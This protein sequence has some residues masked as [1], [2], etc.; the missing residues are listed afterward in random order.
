MSYLENGYSDFLFK[1]FKDGKIVFLSDLKIHAQ[2]GKFRKYRLL[3]IIS[4]SL[5]EATQRARA[6]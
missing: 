2:P 4:Q 3:K 5:T 1:K 6:F